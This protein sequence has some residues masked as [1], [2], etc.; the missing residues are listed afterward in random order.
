MHPSVSKLLNTFI[1]SYKHNNCYICVFVMQI[2]EGNQHY[3]MSALLPEPLR[4]AD[5]II[6]QY[7]VQFAKGHTCGGAYLKLIS[8]AD[9][10]FKT[11]KLKSK[12][13]FSVMFGPDRCGPDSRVRLR[14]GWQDLLKWLLV[15]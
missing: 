11:S 7:E 4:P 10:P 6:V 12:T 8:Q 14:A 15:C 3:G 2:P 5:G 1:P 13:P 9:E